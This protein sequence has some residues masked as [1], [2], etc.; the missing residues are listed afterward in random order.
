MEGEYIPSPLSLPVSLPEISLFI[1][2]M[3]FLFGTEGGWHVCLKFVCGGTYL[4]CKIALEQGLA[5]NFG[6]GRGG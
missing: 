1:V 3:L 5:L 4:A 2:S 6:G